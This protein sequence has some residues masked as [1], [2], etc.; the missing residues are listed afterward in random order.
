MRAIPPKIKDPRVKLSIVGGKQGRKNRFLR[1][2]EEKKAC[3]LSYAY[4]AYVCSGL[5]SRM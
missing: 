1:G 3:N 2:S 5:D 4:A